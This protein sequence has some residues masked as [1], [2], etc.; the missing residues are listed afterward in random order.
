M[1]RI[2]SALGRPLFLVD[3]AEKK[4][5][6]INGPGEEMLGVA[7]ED[8]IGNSWQ[9]YFDEP[10][11]RRI[12]ALIDIIETSGAR[13]GRQELQMTLRRRTGR[14]VKVNLTVTP[15]LSEKQPSWLFEIEDLTPILDLQK[16]KE[17][18][19]AEMSRVSKLA[20]IGRLTGGIAHELNNPLAIMQG[21]VENIEESIENGEISQDSLRQD[22]KPMKDTLTRMIR[23]IQSMM[24][25]ARGEEP[26]M[27]NLPLTEIW[28]RAATSFSALDEFN[29][30]S[31]DVKLNP[32]LR[33]PV[34]SIRVEQVLIN[35]VKNAL[36]ALDG[37]L[38][39]QKHLTVESRETK[40]TI[41]LIVA[42]NGP[43]V[44][45]SAAENLFTPF[46]TT[47]PV[48]KGTGLG[49]FLCYNI[50]KA[51]GGSLKYEQNAPRGAKFL[52]TFPK[53]QRT[54]VVHGPRILVVDDE[55]L[56][57]DLF[58]RKLELWGFAVTEAGSGSEAI[59][60][61]NANPDFELILSDYRM[62]SGD[63]AH[64]VEEIRKKSAVPVIFVTG[65]GATQ[66]IER[67][68]QKGVIQ[69]VIGKPLDDGKLKSL[70]TGIFGAR[71]P[72]AFL[73]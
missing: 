63:G 51:H 2:L 60:L 38:P 5:R 45:P 25:V 9:Q 59:R 58:A 27:E 50:M 53:N 67:L 41:Q 19:V 54:Q 33:I 36:Y 6:F 56:F 14:Q 3:D 12:D 65:F 30:I 48:G 72:Q 55:E 1:E 13:E 37:N 32:A 10:S 22:L 62:P 42:D 44:T 18:L 73:S 71:L 11:N 7:A 43:G 49:L 52:L 34:D 68:V 46:F 20:D 28:S 66:P 4:V 61:M 26:Q 29:G 23:I 35:L 17:L 64:L 21:L 39:G 40:D 47:K 70:L 31:L 24:S 16:E 57:R 69:G 8:A 15:F